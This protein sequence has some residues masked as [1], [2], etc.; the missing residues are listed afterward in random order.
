MHTREGSEGSEPWPVISAVSAWS[1]GVVLGL[2]AYLV[3]IFAM[4][5]M[6]TGAGGMSPRQV[7][8]VFMLMGLLVAC[9]SVVI[10]FW[11]WRKRRPVR[12]LQ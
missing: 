11:Q 6:D 5:D 2:L 3:S 10:E 8:L 1:I 7:V 9:A 12:R 4:P